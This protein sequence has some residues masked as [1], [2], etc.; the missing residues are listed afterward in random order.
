MK[1]AYGVMGYGRGHAARVAAVLPA[2]MRRHEVLVYAAE[3]AY[4][5]LSTRFPC[6]RIPLLRYHYGGDRVSLWR[7][8]TR[9]IGPAS[10]LLLRGAGSRALEARLREQGAE[11]VISD[12][13]PYTHYAARRLGLPRIGFDHIGVIAYCKPHFPTD[14]AWVGHRDAWVYRMLM[15][16]PERILVSSFYPAQPM[17]ED[18]RVLGPILRERVRAARSWRGG[19][20]LAYFNKGHHQFGP[21]QEQ[22]LR[23]AGMPVHVYGTPRRGTDG[24]LQFFAPSESGFVDDLAGC[25]AVICTAGNQLLGEATA[26]RKPILALPEDAFEQKLNA[27]M[28]RKLGIGESASLRDLDAERLAQFIERLDDYRDGIPGF[29]AGGSEQAAE[30]LDDTIRELSARPASEPR[31]SAAARS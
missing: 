15:G 22:A 3:D 27:F 10:D 29:D 13:E 25:E 6:E 19:Y 18:T 31:R 1:I 16:R 21:R 2:L 23:S 26:L 14:L 28:V 20:L 7:T 12:S 5:F 4:D 8:L 30:L 11:L 24:S 17:R 9:N